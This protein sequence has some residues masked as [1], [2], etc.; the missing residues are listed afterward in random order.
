MDR[1]LVI[2][3]DK[4]TRWSLGEAFRQDGFQVDEAAS[5]DEALT[6]AEAATFRLILADIDVQDEQ[7]PARLKEVQGLQPSAAILVLSSDP[8]EQTESA[9]RSLGRFRIIEKPYGMDVIRS[10]AG[11]A[12]Q[13]Q[14]I[15]R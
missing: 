9:L 11:E 7:S 1:I 13:A 10:A 3:E 4:L 15:R 5:W 6:L 12:L 8:A 14:E 2:D